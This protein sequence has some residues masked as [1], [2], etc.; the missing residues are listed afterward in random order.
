MNQDDE[1]PKPISFDDAK[2]DDEHDRSTTAASLKDNSLN[3]NTAKMSAKT[4]SASSTT[5]ANE[6][7]GKGNEVMTLE[8]DDTTTKQKGS[9]QSNLY[10]IQVKK[11]ENSNNF[12]AE[13]YNE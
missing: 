7:G 13:I 9:Q 2:N 1:V 3:L 8:L 5:T 12:D 10:S 6:F 11:E 4:T